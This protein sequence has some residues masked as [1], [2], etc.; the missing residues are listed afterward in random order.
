MDNRKPG[1]E[2]YRLT[3]EEDTYGRT[4]ES[5]SL[6][7]ATLLSIGLTPIMGATVLGLYCLLWG[8]DSLLTATMY[9]RHLYI[10]IPLFLLSVVVHE[11]LHWLGYVA[12]AHLPW[13]SVRPGFDLRSFSAYVHA[14]SPVR[15]SAYRALVALPGVILGLM[16]AVIGIAIGNG[17]ITMYGFIMLVGACGDLVI[18]WKIRRVLTG[19]LVVDHPSRAGCWVLTGKKDEDAG[20]R[21]TQSEIQM[22]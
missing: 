16:P 3:P 13:K 10:V 15:V 11:A 7:Y 19:A 17:L 12:F 22:R 6:G 20:S 1:G 21:K 9:F 5:F 4:D 8:T 18:L 2:E 14:D